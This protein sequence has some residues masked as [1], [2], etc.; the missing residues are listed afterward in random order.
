MALI[1]VARA[2]QVAIMVG[3]RALIT[4]VVPALATIT[5]DRRTSPVATTGQRALAAGRCMAA[6]VVALAGALVAIPVRVALAGLVAAVARA[7][8]R[9]LAPP[10]RAMIGRRSLPLVAVLVRLGV[11]SLT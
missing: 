9:S 6:R 7:T 1:G 4:A 10:S 11:R 2:P 5:A 3:R 8:T